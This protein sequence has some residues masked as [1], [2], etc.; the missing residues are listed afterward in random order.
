MCWHF[1]VYYI[2]SAVAAILDQV[3]SK[4]QKLISC[5]CTPSDYFARVPLK[6]IH[7][8]IRYFAIRQT[9]KHRHYGLHDRLPF[10]T[11]K[12]HGTSRPCEFE[13]DVMILRECIQIYLGLGPEAAWGFYLQVCT[14]VPPSAL[15]CTASWRLYCSPPMENKINKPKPL[16][17][18]HRLDKGDEQYWLRLLPWAAESTT[19]LSESQTPTSRRSAPPR[20]GSCCIQT[21]RDATRTPAGSESPAASGWLRTGK[22][23][24]TSSIRLHG[25]KTWI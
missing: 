23:Q 21:G 5:R 9:N 17:L 4:S 2:G 14:S 25:G 19:P 24:N 12:D 16:K 13:E 22:Q 1:C 18:L 7:W 20:P 8:F 3:N 10:F 6:S 15:L 11:Y